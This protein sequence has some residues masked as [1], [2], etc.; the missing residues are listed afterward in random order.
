VYVYDT[1]LGVVR[2]V[3]CDLWIHEVGIWPVPFPSSHVPHTSYVSNMSL[4]GVAIQFACGR[5]LY[6]VITKS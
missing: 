2:Y 4:T 5:V 6:S 3:V 1:P